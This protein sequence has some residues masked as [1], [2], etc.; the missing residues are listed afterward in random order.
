MH[1]NFPGEVE[2][3]KLKLRHAVD[4]GVIFYLNGAEGHRFGITDDPVNYLSNANGH[5]NA[6]EGPFDFPTT[7]LVTGDN[8][9]TAEVHQSGG[10]SSDMVFGA[11]LSATFFPAGNVTPPP[12]QPKLTVTSTATSVTISWID[13]GELQS[14]D[15]VNGPYTTITPTAA[16]PYVITNQG[17]GT[18]FYRVIK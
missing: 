18:K 1:F 11:E 5:E 4:D 12:T 7:N 3:A 8:L 16:N 9:I 14:A 13:G 10:S 17:T 2:G 15:T 6:Y